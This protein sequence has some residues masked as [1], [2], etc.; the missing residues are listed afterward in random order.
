MIAD[1]K[2]AVDAG[3]P[4]ASILNRPATGGSLPI[5]LK[6]RSDSKCDCCHRQPGSDE[7]PFVEY[8]FADSNNWARLCLDCR[9]DVTHECGQCDGGAVGHHM[10]GC[11]GGACPCDV[12][13][14]ERCCGSARVID[15][16][17][18]AA[19]SLACAEEAA[20]VDFAGEFGEL[21]AIDEVA[22]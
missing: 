22:V 17:K 12:R 13:D 15:V 7:N 2:K 10:R 3:T 14:C 21:P 6:S 9:S 8:P 1:T 20:A 16:E 19:H 5:V 11:M 18:F 4:T